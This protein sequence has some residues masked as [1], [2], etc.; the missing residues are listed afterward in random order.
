MTEAAQ[1]RKVSV[2]AIQEFFLFRPEHGEVQVNSGLGEI[3]FSLSSAQAYFKSGSE[4]SPVAVTKGDL[5]MDF[6]N[7]SFETSLDLYH[8]QLG[9]SR[10]SALGRI[11][12]GGYFHF[13]DGKS[14]IIG[15]Q[16][17]TEASP[18]IFSIFSTGMGSFRALPYGMRSSG[19]SYDSLRIYRQ[20]PTFRIFGGGRCER[21]ISS[22]AGGLLTMTFLFLLGTP[23][24]SIE[25]RAGSLPWRLVADPNPE[26]RITVVSIDERSLAEV[27]PWPWSW[28]VIADLV[29]KINEAGA[30]LQI[31]DILY[32]AGDRDYDER[33]LT[34]LS[35]KEKSIIAQLPII[36]QQ[37]DRL[38]TGSLSHAVSGI[39]CEGSESVEF[40]RASGF[41]GSSTLLSPIPK[42]HMLR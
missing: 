25:E 6:A 20:V 5:L 4:V 40:P 14:R 26:E 9:D 19:F 11:F 36:Q 29:D 8:M 15:A 7:N 2:G 34:S 37:S 10:F 21:R 31:H 28:D 42:G 33:L 24:N 3:G 41:I 23:L 13:R 35:E 22:S 1:G 30:Q 12:D 38:Q 32:P 16:A 27:G 17:R 39:S 18:D